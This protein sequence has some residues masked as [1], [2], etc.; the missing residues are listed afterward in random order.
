MSGMHYA[1]L[2][3]DRCE[4]LDY[5]IGSAMGEGWFNHREHGVNSGRLVSTN[6]W[7]GFVIHYRVDGVVAFFA[8][9]MNGDGASQIFH[10]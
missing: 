1:E 10:L 2:S 5:S 9:V 7:R 6:C 3:V 4:D 8:L